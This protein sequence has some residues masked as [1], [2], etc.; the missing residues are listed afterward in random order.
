MAIV[1]VTEVPGADAGMVDGMKQ[2]GIVEAMESAEGFGGHWSG[3]TRSGYRVIEVWERRED[4]EAWFD[5]HVKPNLPPGA[6]PNEPE[7][8]ELNLEVKPRG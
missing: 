4:W 1:M 8:F 2:A 5:G 7:F 6:Q 3:P